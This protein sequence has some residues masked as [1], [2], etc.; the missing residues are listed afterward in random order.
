MSSTGECSNLIS[1]MDV[2]DEGVLD[3]DLLVDDGSED[4]GEAPPSSD[5]YAGPASTPTSCASSPRGEEPASPH[6]GTQP[7][8]FHHQPYAR[9][10]FTSGRRGPGRPRKEGAKLAREGKI[11][12][13]RDDAL[14]DIMDEDDFT[15]PAPEEPPFM[16]EKWPGK[17]CALCN[18]TERSQLGQGE[19][20][21]FLC[22]IGEGDGSTTPT[23]SNSGGATPTNI[24]T[25]T[26]TPTTPVPPGL[27][28][29]PPELVDPNQ[30]PTPL[31]NMEHTDELSII[32]HVETIELP[33]V[34]S[35]GAFYIHRCCLEFSPPFHDQVAAASSDEDKEQ[36]EEARIKGIMSCSKYF[37]L[38]CILA[39][40]GFMDFQTKSSFCK[41]HLYQ[42]CRGECAAGAAPADSR[43]VTCE[44]CDKTY[45][46]TCL[47]PM[48][49]TVP[50]YGWKCK[51]CRICSD[52]GARSPG[53]G[54]SSRW[55]AHY[56]VCDSCYQQRNKGSC[57][58]L[59]R[60]AY[61]AAAYRDM[62]RYVH[63]MC[64]PEAEPQQYRL[65]KEQSPTYEYNCVENKLVLCSS[66]DKFVLTQD[67]CVMCGA[68]SQ[69]IVTL[70]WRCLDCTV[71]EGCGNRGDEALLVL[72]DDCDTA[73]HTYC[74]RPPL[75]DVPRG[76]WRCERCRKCLTCG[77]RDTHTCAKA[78][79]A[80]CTPLATPSAAR[81][82][83]RPAAVLGLG[84]EYYVDDVCLSQRG[85][86]HMK[87]LEAEMGITHT[88]RKR[89][90][91][92]ETT[93][94]DAV[95]QNAD[96]E[97]PD[98]SKPDSTAEVKEEPGISN[99]NLKEGILWN[100]VNEGPPPEGFTVYTTESGL[101]VLRRKRQRNLNK[102]GIGGFVVR[103]RQTTKT[104]ADDEKDGDGTQASGESPGNKRKPRRKPRSKLMEQ[105]PSY[106]QEAFF[107]K[108][109]LE[110]AKP[111]VSSTGNPSAS[112]GGTARPGTPEGYRE[113]RDFKIDLENSDS[114]GEDV[115]AAL[116]T[117]KD[118]DSSYVIN[119]NSESQESSV[120]YVNS[121]SGTPYSQQ[122]QH[123]LFSDCGGAAWGGDQPSAPP[124]S[125]NQ[126]SAEKMR[127]DE[128]LGPAAT[129]SAV[130]YANTN[131][132]EWKTE[133]PNWVDRCKQILK[134]WRALP[135]E[136]KAP[137]LQRARDNRS[138][139]RMKKAQQEQERA[140]GQQRSAREAEQE[141]QWK[142]L[143]QLRQQQTQHQQQI[144]HDQRVQAAM[145]RLR[146]PEAEAPPPSPAPAPEAP[147]SA[148]PAQRF[149]LHYANN[150]D[151][152]RQLRDLLQRHP[153]KMWPGQAASE[154]GVQQ[155]PEGQPFRHPLPVTVRPRAPLPPGQRPDHQPQSEQK[156]EPGDHGNDEMDMGDM[157]KLEQDTGNI[158]E[159]LKAE[160]GEQ[161]NILEFDDPEL[162]ALDDAE[163]IL[164]GL[165]LDMPPERHVKREHPEEE[166]KPNNK[167]DSELRKSVK[168]IESTQ[169]KPEDDKTTPQHNVNQ[170]MALQVNA[171]L[172]AGRAIAPGTRLVGADGS[173]RCFWRSSWSR[174]S[175]SRSAT[176]SGARRARARRAAAAA[177]AVAAP[178]P[179]PAPPSIPLYAGAPPP[180]PPPPD[181]DPLNRHVYETWLKQYNAFAADQLRYYEGEVQKLRKIR[182]EYET[183]HRQQN[184]QLAQQ[185]VINQQQ[186][187]TNQTVYTQ[188]QNIPQSPQ[189]QQTTIN[190]P[191]QIGLQGSVQ[192]QQI[193]RN[194]QTVLSSD[195][196][197]RI[198]LVTSPLS[199]QG[200][201]LQSGR[202]LV[203]EQTGSP[204]QQL[205]RQLS[206]VQERPQSVGMVQFGQQQLG[207]RSAMPPGSQTPRPA[208]ARPAMSPLHVQSP[209]SQSPLHSL[210]PQSPL[211]HLTSPMQSPLHSQQSPLHHTSQSPLHP[212]TQSPLHTQQS[213]LHSQ[214]SPMHVQQTNIPQQS[215]MHHSPMHPQQSPMHP[216][217]SPLHPQQSPMHQQGNMHPQQSPMHQ[218]SLHQQSQISQQSP[219]HPQQSP[220]HS[221]QSPMHMQQ[222]PMHTQQSPMQ[223]AM[224]PQHF[225]QQLQA[226]RT[227]PQLP[228]PSR[229]P[230]IYQQSQIQSPVSSH[231]P[232]MQTVIV[233]KRIPL[234]K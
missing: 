115:L 188:N 164:D 216:Q 114:D 2:P 11:V 28:S 36:M 12:R 51:C 124:P 170:Q 42:V 69:V 214:Q 14:D 50:K 63:G 75:G 199:A 223:S 64:D 152:N 145:Q 228:T 21:Q 107:G 178:P 46:A 136:Q 171:A 112:P 191:M 194:Q 120:S 156:Q 72:C 41:D 193:I 102:L 138:A 213:P 47:R 189:I 38:P 85:A 122:R 91:K 24:P 56:T 27:A 43:H 210:A 128:S 18:L 127:A 167:I 179:A 79:G 139:I 144:I 141:R 34:V 15:M 183:K 135:S 48:M 131:H 30:H 55:H 31:Y 224:S 155:G 165:E 146:T 166:Q 153:E 190:R 58:P 45:H 137:Y 169:C 233:I 3:V 143:Q 60:R 134:K 180:A 74:A 129:I 9:P 101:T 150:E 205:V 113:L 32:G 77:T 220:M 84:G 174:R 40:G 232:Q 184:P 226:Q 23:V 163:H 78:A 217:Q 160:I 99:A 8:F 76:A 53:A 71:C 96:V 148:F 59:C 212:S 103:Q 234:P 147:R 19:M 123:P 29:P 106:M 22:N 118:N 89:R 52:C 10:F 44:H 196:Q 5:F 227:S 208:G 82:T 100:V 83:Q 222:S 201:I 109:L 66:K 1:K 162:A 37:H 95:V 225:L 116:T 104:Q 172:A 218:P 98:D 173:N 13:S 142:Q 130:L 92:N 65:K 176:A 231:S 54:P 81:L 209:H 230:Q 62:I 195:G 33:A 4:E 126:R 108:E 119:L 204:Q 158:G 186:I 215:P 35:S 25:P 192:Q 140:C 133:F 177:A 197:Q 67:L 87:Q 159:S 181:A 202:T 68:V 90:F 161:F 229:S 219:M 185:T 80:G 16:P 73:W 17:S 157:D 61:R 105:F 221:Q 88:R 175:V 121:M 110:P 7:A 206:G 149:P 6:G 200:R 97:M 93:E 168:N 117:F 132:P 111:A 86:H 151:I 20:R 57:C 182:K 26:S 49:A 211:H 207:V 39:S 154:E 125:Y 198:G 203:I 187:T 70:G 94:K